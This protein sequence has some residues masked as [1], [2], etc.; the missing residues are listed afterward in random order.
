[1]RQSAL[2]RRLLFAR[3]GNGTILF[4]AKPRGRASDLG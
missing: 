1:M 4:A 2:L 3:L